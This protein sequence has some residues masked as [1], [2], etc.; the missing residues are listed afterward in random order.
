MQEVTT[1]QES[2][3]NE[4][5][6]QKLSYAR[7]KEIIINLYQGLKNEISSRRDQEHQKNL[8]KSLEKFGIAEN[9]RESA[10]KLVNWFEKN[11][12]VGGVLD[13]KT[14]QYIHDFFTFRAEDFKVLA[15]LC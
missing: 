8:K 15:D 6:K 11:V 4:E 2:Q 10:L 13:K 1:G 3:K 9:A 12:I 5:K 7:I 14:N